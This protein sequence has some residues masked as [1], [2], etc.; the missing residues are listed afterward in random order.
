MVL[1]NLRLK[2]SGVDLCGISLPVYHNQAAAQENPSGAV[3]SQPL[4][5]IKPWCQVLYKLCFTPTTDDESELESNQNGLLKTNVQRILFT[6]LVPL[7][8]SVGDEGL[9]SSRGQVYLSVHSSLLLQKQEITHNG[10]DGTM[11]NMK[12]V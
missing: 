8:C 9:F 1:P 5:N 10:N 7:F 6:D 12:D 11:D 3:R 4:L 2:G